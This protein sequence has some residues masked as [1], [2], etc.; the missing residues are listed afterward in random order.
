[1]Q[2]LDQEKSNEIIKLKN[3]LAALNAEREDY[4]VQVSDLNDVVTA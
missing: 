3:D 2:A 4:Q 1:M